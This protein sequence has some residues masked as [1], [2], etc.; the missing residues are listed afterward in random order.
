MC[1][2]AAVI[3][4]IR[5]VLFKQKT[6]YDLRISD[7][8]SDVFSS[9]LVA[10]RGVEDLSVGGL[11]GGLQERLTLGDLVVRRHQ[12]AGLGHLGDRVCGDR[13]GDQVGSGRLAEA[14]KSV[15]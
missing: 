4:L 2:W 10:D 8:S 13:V 9:D 11:L 14:R 6:A 15:V 7:W 1:V 12:I 3:S 5:V